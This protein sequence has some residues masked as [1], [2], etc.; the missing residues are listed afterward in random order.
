MVGAAGSKKNSVGK[1]TLNLYTS[2]FTSHSHIHNDFST[3]N[4]MLMIVVNKFM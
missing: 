1:K 3:T 2:E 4:R